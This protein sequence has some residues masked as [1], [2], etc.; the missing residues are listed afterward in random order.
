MATCKISVAFLRYSALSIMHCSTKLCLYVFSLCVRGRWVLRESRDLKEALD[1]LAA[2]GPVECLCRA[3]W[4]V[5]LTAVS[6]YGGS[7][8]W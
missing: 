4:W 6:L 8:Y 7:N 3:K 1:L 5:T 2:Q